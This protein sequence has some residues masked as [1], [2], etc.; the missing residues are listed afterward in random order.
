MTYHD[1]IR[2][3]F[4]IMEIEAWFLGMYNIFQRIDQVLTVQYIKQNLGID[5]I[6]VDPQKAFYKPTKQIQQIFRLCGRDY[7]KKESDIECVCSVMQLA[8][9]GDVRENNR[10]SCFNNFYREIVAFSSPA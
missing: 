1:K 2:L 3:Y 7:S 6:S 8:D 9:F 10:C 4:A 5:L